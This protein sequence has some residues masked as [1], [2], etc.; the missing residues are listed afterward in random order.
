MR[1][2]SAYALVADG[3]Y[4]AMVE[5]RFVWLLLELGI[6]LCDV[7]DT[8]QLFPSHVGACPDRRATYMLLY[9]ADQGL[10]QLTQDANR[11]VNI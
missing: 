2:H 6:Y 1:M 8:T 9:H 4:L 11:H 5:V 10:I 7:R 3:R